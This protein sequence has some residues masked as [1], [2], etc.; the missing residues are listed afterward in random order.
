MIT[1]RNGTP[2]KISDVADVQI[3]AAIK[4]GNDKATFAGGV[5]G[6]PEV[7]PA[8]TFPCFA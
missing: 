5:S 7:A 3:G 8:F 4:R 6:K 2:V 1:A